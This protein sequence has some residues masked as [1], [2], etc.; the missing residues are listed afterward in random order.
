MLI[1]RV[2]LINNEVLGARKASKNNYKAVN[3][4]P[5]MFS[6]NPVVAEKSFLKKAAEFIGELRAEKPKLGVED[7]DDYWQWL[8]VHS[9]K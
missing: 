9:R 2:T 5:M 3:Q 8:I 4:S 7:D 6:R 1:N